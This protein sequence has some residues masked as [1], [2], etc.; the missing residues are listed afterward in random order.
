MTTTTFRA[1]TA[2]LQQIDWAA[3]GHRIDNGI[4][5]V[6]IAAEL[7]LMVAAMAWDIAYEHRREIRDALVRAAA[8]T[9]LAGVRTRRLA[10]RCY[11][12]GAWT[13]LQLLALSDRAASLTTV[14]PVPAVAPITATLAA[15]REALE[16]LVRQLYLEAM[17]SI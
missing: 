7:L 13:R 10:E 16:R 5:Y 6:T 15:V 8:S 4:R 1:A 2:R 11:R 9:Y 14:Q 12:A 3:I 17:E